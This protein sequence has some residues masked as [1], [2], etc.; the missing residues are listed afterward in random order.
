[1]IIE[2]QIVN[3][4]HC[5]NSS[6]GVKR[7]TKSVYTQFSVNSRIFRSFRIYKRDEDYRIEMKKKI[8]KNKIKLVIRYARLFNVLC[9]H[10]FL[11]TVI[12]QS[13]EGRSHRSSLFCNLVV[14]LPPLFCILLPCK[15]LFRIKCAASRIDGKI[16]VHY[17]II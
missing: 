12:S 15:H 11:Y 1:M 7:P 16:T 17:R 14:L 6:Q 8:T 13:D 9:R 4:K 3:V 5:K 2:F 10:I